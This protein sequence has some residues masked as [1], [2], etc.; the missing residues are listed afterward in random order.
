MNETEATVIPFPSSDPRPNS[1]GA[2]M[3]HLLAPPALAWLG[4]VGS[5]VTPRSWAICPVRTQ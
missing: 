5:Q 3:S 4:L 2:R 1:E